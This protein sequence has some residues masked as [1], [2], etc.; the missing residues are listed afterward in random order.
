M[1]RQR[2]DAPKDAI[3]RNLGNVQATGDGI[4]GT[5]SKVSYRRVCESRSQVSAGGQCV[6]R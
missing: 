2:G 4:S 3:Q 1:E 6:E 5:L